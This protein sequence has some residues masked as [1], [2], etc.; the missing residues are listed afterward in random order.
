MKGKWP[1]RAG[2]LIL[3]WSAAACQQ[4]PAPTDEVQPNNAVLERDNQLEP[5]ENTV[6]P[7]TKGKSIL[8]PLVEE[9]AQNTPQLETARA[10]VLFDDRTDALDDTTRETLDEILETPTMQAGGP[11]ILRGHSDSR[12]SDGDNL[13]ASKHRAETVRD[14]LESKHVAPDR[15]RVIALGETRP[16]APNAN[17]DGSDNPEGRARNRRV[18]IEVQPPPSGE[19][20]GTPDAQP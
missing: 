7:E 18:E 9:E 15:I 13:V 4:H 10:V 14:Y 16:I 1:I 6:E 17:E 3:L 2:S 19:K 5:A 11:I 20:Q 12:G 8:R